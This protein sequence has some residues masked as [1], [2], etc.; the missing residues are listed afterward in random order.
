MEVLETSRSP[1]TTIR[2]PKR[3]VR[4]LRA[5]AWTELVLC[6]WLGLIL[7]AAPVA[8]GPAPFGIAMLSAM[9]FGIGSVLCLLGSLLGYFAGFGLQAGAQMAGGCCLVFM[10]NYFL[11]SNR[12]RRGKGLSVLM[13]AAAYGVTRGALY[14]LTGG[15]SVLILVR[16]GFYL[17]LC[18]ACAYLFDDV[19]DLREPR[20]LSAELS[21]P[22]VSHDIRWQNPL[23]CHFAGSQ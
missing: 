10:A 18:A 19:M 15:I 13:A 8:E 1:Q 21:F 16:L 23:C 5:P 4:A 22:L 7:S 17:L 3:L 9:E 11:R 2:G 14:L 6:F 12:L 20:T